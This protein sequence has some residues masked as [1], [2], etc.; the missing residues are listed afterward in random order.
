M[1]YTDIFKNRA[2][3]SVLC[4]YDME[5][6]AVEEIFRFPYVIEAPNWS[7]DG[8]YFYYN[9]YGKIYRFDIAT[10]EFQEVNTGIADTCNNDHVPGPDGKKLAVSSG[11]KNDMNSYIFVVDLET[12][13]TEKVINQTF[14]YL[15]GWSPDGKKL[16]YCAGRN[17]GAPELEWDIYI[18]NT[19]GSEETRL[20]RTYGLNDGSEFSPDG[21]KIWFNSVRSGRM[22]IWNMNPNGSEQTQMT[23]DDTMNA[24]FAHV[25]PDGKQVVYIAYHQEDLK[26][27]EH[28]PDK[29]VEIRTIPAE[30]GKE[31]TLLKLFGGQGSMNVNSWSPDSKKFAFVKYEYETA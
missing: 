29:E 5:S 17:H 19:D 23:F 26:I 16:V 15:H 7:R 24:W 18:A 30:G 14:S 9:S 8:K 1:G 25:S 27:E 20:T 2:Q 21:K 31:K 28:V 12:G 4:S 22:Q 13:E 6:G 3:I 10:K 11:E